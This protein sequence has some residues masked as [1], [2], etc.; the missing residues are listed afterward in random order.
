L[1]DFSKCNGNGSCL[2]QFRNVN[3]CLYAAFNVAYFDE[4]SVDKAYF[5]DFVNGDWNP[6]TT[7][8]VKLVCNQDGKISVE[9]Y[10]EI[11]YGNGENDVKGG[12]LSLS[13][14]IPFIG[15]EASA[16][17][18]Y[19]LESTWEESYGSTVKAVVT[20][21]DYEDTIDKTDKFTHGCMWRPKVTAFNRLK[22]ETLI[23]NPPIIKCTRSAHPPKCGPFM[24]C[25]HKYCKPEGCIPEDQPPVDEPYKKR[26]VK[27]NI[28]QI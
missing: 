18:S 2:L 4:C 25:K 20:C 16:T 27:K 26:K 10:N 15:V 8:F 22:K 14:E 24:K 7:D 28:L 5:F 23:W 1:W 9:L 21:E 17:A 11:K 13:K 3:K 6:S 12:E 19:S